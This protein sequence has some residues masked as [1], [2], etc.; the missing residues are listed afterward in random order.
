MMPQESKT[1]LSRKFLSISVATTRQCTLERRPLK[2][3]GVECHWSV[4][5]VLDTKDTSF[6]CR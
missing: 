5:H 1:L 6:G 4:K 3:E 2:K